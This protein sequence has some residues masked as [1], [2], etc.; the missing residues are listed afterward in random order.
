M[1]AASGTK[2]VLYNIQCLPVCAHLPKY[3]LFIIFC[4]SSATFW[5]S[6][7]KSITLEEKLSRDVLPNRVLD[8]YSYTHTTSLASNHLILVLTREQYKKN[9]HFYESV[10]SNLI[11]MNQCVKD[12]ANIIQ[13][14]QIC[15]KINF[16]MYL[17]FIRR[18]WNLKQ[19][20]FNFFSKLIVETST[21]LDEFLL[22]FKRKTHSQKKFSVCRSVNSL[23]WF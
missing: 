2:C 8:N 4:P 6:L 5:D 15:I 20:F 21:C 9:Q 17:E 7:N 11:K 23:T 3:F 14:Y 16:K 1:L 10:S 18:H 22:N 19:A 13:A 12:P